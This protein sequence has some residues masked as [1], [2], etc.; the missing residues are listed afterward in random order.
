MSPYAASIIV[1]S[2][3]S[4]PGEA[5]AEDKRLVIDYS[6][7]NKQIPKVQTTQAKSNGS[8]ALIEMAK[9]TTSGQN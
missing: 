9:K 6:E 7:L 3:K 5:L 1:A 8:V 2:R 4:K